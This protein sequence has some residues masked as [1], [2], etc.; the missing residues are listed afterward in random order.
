VE[1]PP[2]TYAVLGRRIPVAGGGYF[3]LYPYWLTRYFL[4]RINTIDEKPFIFYLHPWEVDPDQPRI[5]TNLRSRFRHYT[6]LDKTEPRLRRLI[7]DF[8]FATVRHVIERLGL[9]SRDGSH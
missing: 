3:R 1:F 2:T 7:A 6:N 4:N 9:L 5:R 8:E